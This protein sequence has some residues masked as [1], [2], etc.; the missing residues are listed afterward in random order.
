MSAPIA[1]QAAPSGAPALS[2]N[3]CVDRRLVHRASIAEVFL[4]DW[5]M[6]SGGLRI[7][8]QLPHAHVLMDDSLCELALLVEVARQSAILAA[9]EIYDVPYDNAFV[10]K[11]LD[12][13]LGDGV[14]DTLGNE[15]I[16]LDV[17][18]K[19]EVIT[20]KRA[21]PI[22]YL[23]NVTVSTIQGAL[24]V[25]A[26]GAMSA[27]TVKQ[28]QIIA[29]RRGNRIAEPLSQVP[30]EVPETVG[31]HALGNMAITRIQ[32]TPEFYW[33]FLH[34]DQP[35]PLHFDH[36]QD[37][38]PGTLIIEAFR[39]LAIGCHQRVFGISPDLRTCQLSLELLDF[40]EIAQR[41][42]LSAVNASAS[43]ME[44]SVTWTV[45]LAQSGRTC[46]SGTVT[47]GIAEA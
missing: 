13:R 10:F 41:A 8:A 30:P 42:K 33:A 3:R 24:L 16:D 44:N 47:T 21:K 36:P 12:T 11:T 6:V 17:S 28:Q 40:C 22:G 4:T 43:P 23:F 5:Q 9:H 19:A 29:A 15:P 32:Q 45:Q 2:R 25:R 14:A 7:A 26:S 39:Q 37:H 1:P 20:N 27:L 18:L 46:A 34:V 38:V 31:H 35:H